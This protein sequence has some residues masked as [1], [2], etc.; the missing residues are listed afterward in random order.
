MPVSNNPVLS[1]IIFTKRWLISPWSWWLEAV[2]TLL[3]PSSTKLKGGILVSLCPSVDRILSALYLPQYLP[4]PFHIY[5]AFQAT[6]GV[7][8]V[9]YFSNLWNFGKSF[10]FVTLTLSYFDLGYNKKQYGWSWEGGWGGGGGGGGGVS[11]ECRRSNF[12]WI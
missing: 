4:D 7:S 5:T 2:D 1:Q 10:K 12:I 11:S 9:I 6:S 3:Y 8:S